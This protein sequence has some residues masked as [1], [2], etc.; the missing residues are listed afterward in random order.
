MKNSLNTKIIL[1]RIASEK[2][3]LK[4]MG[5]RKIGIFGSY[6]KNKQKYKSDIDFLVDFRVIDLDR[7]LYVLNLLEKMF[8]KKIDLVIESDL[9]PELKY[10]KREAKYARI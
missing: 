2:E 8:R 4:E 1:K 5:V 6:A 7:Y 9:K 3:K 10:V